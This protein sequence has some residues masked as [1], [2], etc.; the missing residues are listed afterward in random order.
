MSATLG[1]IGFPIGHSIS[2]VFQQAA[3]D[4]LG[5]DATYQAWE[6]APEGVGEFLQALRQPDKLGINVTVPHKEAVIPFLDEVDEG[7]REAGADNTIVHREGQ[8]TG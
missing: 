3:L 7:A 1:I 8:L 5:I 6:V 4:H 2:P